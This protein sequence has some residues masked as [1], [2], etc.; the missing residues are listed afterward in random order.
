MTSTSQLMIN[1]PSDVLHHVINWLQLSFLLIFAT[2]DA[3]KYILLY[4]LCPNWT[5]AKIQ[6]HLNIPQLN[7][8]MH[9]FNHTNYGRRVE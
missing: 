5:D 3:M 8:N 1:R 6:I 7:R 9:H 4:T 2:F